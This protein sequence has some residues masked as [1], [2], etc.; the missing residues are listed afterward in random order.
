MKKLIVSLF[1]ACMTIGYA[2]AENTDV[3][4]I[5]NVV[6]ITPCTVFPG[7]QTT[8]SIQM[9]NTA[10]IRSFQFDLYLPDG[11]S[12]VK[13]AKGKIQGA[14]NP[15]RLPEEDEHTLTF[16]EQPDGAIRFL[17]GSEFAETFTGTDG[18]IA[19]L[20]INVAADVV[21]GDYP[22]YIRNIVLSENDIANHY[23][24]ELV[25]S[26]ITVGGPAETRV[27]F[28][29]TS[30]SMLVN[31][32]PATNADVRVKRT[33]K[34]NEWSTL[35]LPFAVTKAQLEQA[36]GEGVNV[37]L[38]D[39]TSWSS[40]KDADGNTVGITV[41][42][43]TIT[44][45]AAN[46]PC[47]IKTNAN[48]TEFTLDGVN[49]EELEEEPT[50]QVDDKAYL[51]GTYVA[52]T[53]VPKNKLFLNGNQFWYS[54]GQ[55]KMK[56]M[57]AYFD[58]YDVLTSVEDGGAAKIRFQFENNNATAIQTIAANAEDNVIYSI[59]GVRMGTA[60]KLK[61]LPKGLYIVNGKKV[62]IK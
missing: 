45:V 51:Y 54:M 50:V 46:H 11:V 5:D 14:L 55:T 42:F 49:I 62:I 24:T 6:Y 35:V 48:V 26:T 23:D 19:T 22:V 58:F 40:K 31:I 47:I 8:L 15:D 43:T 17:S 1:F 13:S 37:D 27:V 3:S 56:A 30:T 41:V 39:F 57:R 60:D 32:E 25:E 33:I 52:G 36:F 38:A 61:A 34:A 18:V 29:E 12:V 59:N 9:K 28:D 53:T 16:S 7:T 10:E 20:K 21:A 2:Y 4:T 44:D